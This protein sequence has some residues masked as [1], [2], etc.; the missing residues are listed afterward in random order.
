MIDPHGH[1]RDWKQSDKET[2]LHGMT[3]AAMAGFTDLFDMPNTNPPCTD[4]QTIL[5]RLAAG[6]EAEERTGVSYHLYAGLTADPE[7]IRT[8]AGLH[9]ELF[10]LVIGLKMFAGQSTGNMGIIGKDRQHAVFQILSDGYGAVS[11]SS[12]CSSFSNRQCPGSPANVMDGPGAP[13][14]AATEVS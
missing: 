13:R 9:S 5:D 11:H 7:E 4:R 10:P 8:M 1:L 6:S 3:V 14:K 12:T 2:I